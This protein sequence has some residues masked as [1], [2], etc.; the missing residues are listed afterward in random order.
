[1]DESTPQALLH[2]MARARQFAAGQ[3]VFHVGD[4]A[5][6]V[7]RVVQGEVQLYRYDVE[8]QKILL[9]RAMS[10]DFFAEASLNTPRYHCTAVCPKA[11]E[12]TLFD[13]ARIRDLLSSNADFAAYWVNHL[14]TELRRQRASVERL[15]LK[16]AAQRVV[17]FLMTEGE[18]AGELMLNGTISDLAAM[19]G[20]SREALYRTLSKMKKQG[21]LQ[22]QGHYLK[23]IMKN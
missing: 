23:L 22:Q 4:R 11:S 17:H 2:S 14:S 1:M 8:G 9:H 12:V 5:E 21:R 19:L 6:A 16:T 10:G 15:S 3:V 7:Y 18:P 20:L 13:S